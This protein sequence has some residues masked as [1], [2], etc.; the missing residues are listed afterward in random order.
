[1]KCKIC[2][3]CGKPV[4]KGFRSQYRIIQKKWTGCGADVSAEQRKLDICEGCMNLIIKGIKREDIERI[5][6]EE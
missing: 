4:E 3:I 6:R 5:K 1:M 2:D